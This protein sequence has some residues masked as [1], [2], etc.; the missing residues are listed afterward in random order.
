MLSTPVRSRSTTALFAVVDLETTGCDRLADRALSIGLVLADAT[1]APVSTWH[2]LVDPGREVEITASHIHGITRAHLAQAPSF[3]DVA[4]ALL[5]HLDGRSLVAH[6]APFDLGILD[7]E[8]AR[9][10]LSRPDADVVC[11][12]DTARRV[13]EGSHTLRACCDRYGITLDQPHE[14]LPDALATAA[15]LARFIAD[16][17]IH[18]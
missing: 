13:F 2:T 3:A 17:H 15:L 4:S 14:A 10:G 8:F 5:D 7:A 9:V 6:N 12:L 16:G 1:G 18:P 11:T